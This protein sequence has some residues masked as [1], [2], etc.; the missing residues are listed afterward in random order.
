MAKFLEFV[1]G[2]QKY[3]VPVKDVIAV[4]QFH[5]AT[6]AMR[7]PNYVLGTTEYKG[8]VTPI[9]DLKAVLGIPQGTSCNGRMLI[10]IYINYSYSAILADDVLGVIEVDPCRITR[11]EALDFN[12]F[13][14]ETWAINGEN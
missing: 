11:V 5:K 6:K 9:V 12:I 3:G 4:S 14:L 13:W 1:L 10:N 8:H 7:S 2:N